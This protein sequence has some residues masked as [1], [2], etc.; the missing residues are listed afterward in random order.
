MTNLIIEKDKEI[1][2][3][4]N[5]DDNFQWEIV[6]L[7]YENKYRVLLRCKKCGFEKKVPSIHKIEGTCECI[8]CRKEKHR[9]ASAGDIVNNY[10]LLENIYTEKAQVLVKCN[11]CNT[12]H[13][14]KYNDITDKN[15]RCMNCMLNAK[16]PK[17]GTIINNW[18]IIEDVKRMTVPVKC[19][20]LL[21]GLTYELDY[22]TIY[23]KE[24]N[25]C[26]HRK[27]SISGEYN[28]PITTSKW[29]LIGREK[30]KWYRLKCNRCGTE[31][32][33][34]LNNPDIDLDKVNCKFCNSRKGMVTLYNNDESKPF[35]I[36][37]YSVGRFK[38]QCKK[39]GHMQIFKSFTKIDN[40]QCEICNKQES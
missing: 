26:R 31:T 27:R 36:L 20:C 14:I 8:K 23:K 5:N 11:T 21:C 30:N 25:T 35:T 2:D 10:T 38:A 15:H 13:R 12:E 18:E 39:C 29:A 1:L 40:A 16:Y 7:H 3:K 24:H 33:A 22:R 19:K 28:K 4:Y 6:D 34:T 9:I 32:V 37:E 17:A